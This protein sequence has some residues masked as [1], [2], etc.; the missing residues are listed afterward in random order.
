MEADEIIAILGLEPLPD[1]GGMWAQSWRDDS[2]NAIYFLLRPG[3]FSALHRL[4]TTELWHF[5][6]GAPVELTLLGEDGHQRHRLG[7]DLR[8]GHRPM[9]PVPAGT[10]MGATTGG[11][12]SLLGT[13]VAPPFEWENFELGQR[14]ALLKRFPEAADSIRRLT[15]D[16]PAPGTDHAGSD[17]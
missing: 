11:D 1:E 15:R 3:D 12:W 8:A 4:T 10:W 2:G 14:D 5:Y 13:T 17:H 7:P 9:I 16:E 6:C